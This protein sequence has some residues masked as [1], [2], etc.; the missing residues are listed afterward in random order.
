MLRDELPDVE[1]IESPEEIRKRQQNEFYDKFQQSMTRGQSFDS[2]KQYLDFAEDLVPFD[3]T[4]EVVQYADKV[5][6]Q[7][8][9]K[10]LKEEK[11]R[12]EEQTAYQ[13]RKARA[14][15]EYE[16]TLR[17]F[18]RDGVFYDDAT[19]RYVSAPR[20][21]DPELEKRQIKADKDKAVTDEL[22]A[23]E[24]PEDWAIIDAN[25]DPTK[26]EPRIVPRDLIGKPIT[27]GDQV[28]GRYDEIEIEGWKNPY[29]IKM[30]EEKRKTSESPDDQ[31]VVWTPKGYIQQ[32]LPRSQAELIVS[33]WPEARIETQT[34]RTP[35]F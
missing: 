18:G 35:G 28:I 27:K 20:K 9:P 25:P 26:Y 10:K 8:M 1:P 21:L 3:A 15:E 17:D 19:G 32:L 31:V 16:E 12:I 33:Q 34:Q 13:Q 4:P 6:E 7:Y 2:L 11:L 30:N 14:K 5:I 23:K 22:M 24:V 29:W